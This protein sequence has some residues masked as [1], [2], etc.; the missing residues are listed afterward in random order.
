MLLTDIIQG[1]PEWV[2]A[3]KGLVTG[4]RFQSALSTDRTR[5]PD[6]WG[7]AAMDLAL[8]IAAERLGIDDEEGVQTAMMA[9]GNELQ[10]AALDLYELTT[11]REVE[12]D[13]FLMHESDAIGVSPDG[14]VGERE[15][16]VEVK[17]M[18]LARHVECLLKRSVPSEYRAQVQGE[19]W[20][21]D[22]KW[23]DFVSYHPDME[24]LR[25]LAVIRVERDEK[26]IAHMMGRVRGLLR[27]A[28]DYAAQLG[29]KDWKP[30]AL[31]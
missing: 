31:R 3:R 6:T 1:T 19:M 21:A 16:V 4:S 13:R 27:F 28:D 11:F 12:R 8:V 2:E 23:C 15:G 14:I 9:R 20:A 22:A 30:Y 10:N 25:K 17:C 18:K 5:K 7:A 29:V 26:Y 24:G